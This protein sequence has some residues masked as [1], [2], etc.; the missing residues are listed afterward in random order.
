MK[1]ETINDCILYINRKYEN[2]A[3]A[4]GQFDKV[5]KMIDNMVAELKKEQLDDEHKQ[6]S[7]AAQRDPTTAIKCV[8]HKLDLLDAEQLNAQNRACSLQ[9]QV[10]QLLNLT[11][12]GGVSLRGP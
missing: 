9:L 8:K 6:E 3:L 2:K 5:V 7:G 11:S 12:G 4:K 10:D 1:Q